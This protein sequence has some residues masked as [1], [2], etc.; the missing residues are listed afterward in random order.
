MAALEASVAAAK[1]SR[2]HHPAA[3]AAAQRGT[4][5]QQPVAKKTAAKKSA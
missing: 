4:M 1:V 3:K 2:D 5:T